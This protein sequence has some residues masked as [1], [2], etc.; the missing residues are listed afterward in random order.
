M[1]VRVAVK[2]LAQV[3]IDPA[4]SH[5][6][7]LNAGKLRSELGF[8]ERKTSGVIHFLVY[9]SDDRPPVLEEEQFTLYDARTPPRSEWRLYYTRESIASFARAGDLMLLFR[10]SARSTRLIAIIARAG[11]RSEREFARQVAGKDPKDILRT[12]FFDSPALDAAGLEAVLQPLDF[13]ESEAPPPF[14]YSSHPLV[15]R[16]IDR[17]TLPNT[18][19]MAAA[20]HEILLHSFPRGLAPDEFIEEALDAESQL[21]FT[22]EGLLG[23]RDLME[24][25]KSEKL[26]FAGMMTLATRYSQARKSRRGESLQNHFAALLDQRRIPY[27]PQCRTERRET[28][29]FIIPG[30]DAYHDP[31]FPEDR[32]RMVGC[33]TKLRERYRQ[34]LK[35]AKRVEVKFGL[36]VDEG[37]SDNV[38]TGYKEQLRFFL[39]RRVLRRVYDDRK[40]RPLLGTVTEL[41]VELEAVS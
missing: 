33:K 35:E 13:P 36:C 8:P 23:N 1:P 24:L 21:F 30:C 7:E 32:L 20:A 10:P 29:D 18:R 2:R 5:Q 27:T 12:V 26:D 17:R 31:R 25:R 19:E 41:V 11:T 38:V 14:V 39:P 4:S 3:E 22:I 6:H 9:T 34:L 16:S 40:C 15:K 28:P 37:L